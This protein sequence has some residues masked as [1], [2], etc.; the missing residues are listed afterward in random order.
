MLRDEDGD[1]SCVSCG[2]VIVLMRRVSSVPLGLQ[3]KQG[4]FIRAR[5]T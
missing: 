5:R 2:G 1:A 3:K 4:T